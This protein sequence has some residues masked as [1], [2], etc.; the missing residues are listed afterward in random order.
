MGQKRP[1]PI[2]APDLFVNMAPIVVLRGTRSAV[3]YYKMLLQELQERVEQGQGALLKERHRLLWD[4]IAIWHRV[5]S[6]YGHFTAHDA[7][8]VVDSYTGAWSN[9]FDTGINPLRSLAKSCTDIFLNQ[10]LKPREDLLVQ[11][12]E[13]YQVDAFVMHANRSCKPY[14]QLQYDLQRLVT[15]RTGA[16]G[17]IIEADMCDPRNFAQESIKTRIEAFLENLA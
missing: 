15:Q 16:V 6:F 13:D 4:N 2:N 11:M 3:Y 1:S 12:I 7:C 5:L 10:G 8:F 14:T 17:L 9:K